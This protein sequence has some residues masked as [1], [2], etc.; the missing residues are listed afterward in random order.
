MV[1]LSLPQNS[2]IDK[3]AGKIHKTANKNA[4]NIKIVEVYRYDPEDKDKKILTL[5]DSRLILILVVQWFL[6]C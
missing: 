4:K 1:Q 3:K 6:I 2:K 5:I